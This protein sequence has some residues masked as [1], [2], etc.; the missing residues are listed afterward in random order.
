MPACLGPIGTFTG[1]GPGDGVQLGG[2]FPFDPDVDGATPQGETGLVSAR[3]CRLARAERRRWIREVV[4][5]TWVPQLR[6]SSGHMTGA[7]L[8]P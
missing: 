6:R 2:Q 7:G 5:D 8:Q 3:G 1:E 4:A